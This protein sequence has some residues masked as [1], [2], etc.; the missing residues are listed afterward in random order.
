MLFG[1]LSQIGI[2]TNI[3]NDSVLILFCLLN[4]MFIKA[5]GYITYTGLIKHY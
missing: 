4:N 5:D 1:F 2:Y 3:D